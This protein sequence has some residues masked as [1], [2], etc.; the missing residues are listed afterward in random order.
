MK[1]LQL[2]IAASGFLA[3]TLF[4]GEAKAAGGLCDFIGKA[5]QNGCYVSVAKRTLVASTME[6]GCEP[7]VAAATI[8]EYVSYDVPLDTAP[9]PMAL[10]SEKVG[11]N[12]YFEVWPQGDSITYAWSS[13]GSIVLDPASGTANPVR[14]FSCT[15]GTQGTITVKAFSPS[16]ASET[17]TQTVSCQ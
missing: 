17:L 10:E 4:T 14:G 16:G 7:A 6:G 3:V 13:T 11:S 12:R 9:G 2:S 5:C 1:T 8:G 15:V